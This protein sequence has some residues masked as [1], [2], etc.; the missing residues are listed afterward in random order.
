M[1][2]E[3][4]L[5]LKVSLNSGEKW[6]FESLSRHHTPGW[7]NRQRQPLNLRLSLQIQ[8]SPPNTRSTECGRYSPGCWF[9]SGMRLHVP[10]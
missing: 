5:K 10:R 3:R 1:R 2:K 9:E 6:G 8:Y 4:K 7:P